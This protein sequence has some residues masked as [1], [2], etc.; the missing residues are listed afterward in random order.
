M[1]LQDYIRVLRAH[2]RG[3][4]ALTVAGLIFAIAYNYTQPK[5][6]AANA[7]AFVSTGTSTNAA[8]GSVGD[9]LAKSRAASY[10]EL[11]KG[12][13]VAQLVIDKLGLSSTPDGLIG[14]ITVV[15]PSDTVTLQIT[16]RSKSPSQAQQLADAW[17][18]ALSEAVEDVE[19]PDHQQGVETIKVL[20]IAA[21]ALPTSPV[22]PR[23]RLNLMIGLVAGFVVG[24]AYALLRNLLD[25]RLRDAEQVEQ[26]FK[27]SVIGAV[28]DSKYLTHDPEGP[29]PIAVQDQASGTG[30]IVAEVFRKMRTNLSYMDVDNPPRVM[31]VTSPRPNDGKSTVSANLAA[32]IAKSGTKTIYV[33]GDLRRPTVTKYMGGVAGAGLTDILV[34]AAQPE[35]VMQD[36]ARIPELKMIG[37]GQIPPNPS[38][39]LGS[40]AMRHLLQRLSQD[41]IVIIDAPPLLPVTDAAILTR[42]ADG[43]LVVIRAGRTLDQELEVALNNI[44]T[45]NGRTLGVVMNRFKDRGNA[46]YLY[47]YYYGEEEGPKRSNKGTKSAKPVKVSG[48]KRS[49]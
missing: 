3:V 7:T 29:G 46:K 9:S 25:K 8:V 18:Q 21:A 35:D 26:K 32:A 11:A 39:L 14:D 5:I 28:P 1:E 47:G 15:Q 40:Q 37:A 10:V 44:S 16:A 22:S 41:A 30:R 13:K 4:A 49:K 27:V 36:V 19:N 2:W 43:A 23:T 24:M 48:G 42:Q 20:P 33:D 17:V 12:R 38:E 31:V 45:V 34:G 6:Y